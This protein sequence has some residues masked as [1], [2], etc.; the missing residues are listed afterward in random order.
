[1]TGA[2][3]EGRVQNRVSEACNWGLESLRSWWREH[4]AARIDTAQGA[5]VGEAALSSEA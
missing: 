4:L 1:M 5:A 3:A 2:W